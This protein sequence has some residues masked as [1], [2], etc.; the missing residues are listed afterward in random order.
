MIN[1][2]NFHRAFLRFQ[3]QSKLFLNRGEKRRPGFWTIVR[4]GLAA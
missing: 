2:E 3:F 4:A 1:D